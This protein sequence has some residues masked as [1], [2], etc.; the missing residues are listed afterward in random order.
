MASGDVGM[1]SLDG[2]PEFRHEQKL[3]K[4]GVEWQRSTRNPK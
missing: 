4:A 2:A 1:E 3:T